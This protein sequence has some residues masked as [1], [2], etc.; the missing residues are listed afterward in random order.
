[1]EVM[2]VGDAPDRNLYF[3]MCNVLKVNLSAG[4][5]VYVSLL[6][7]AFGQVCVDV[8]HQLLVYCYIIIYKL[9]SGCLYWNMMCVVGLIVYLLNSFVGN[10][11]MLILIFLVILLF[12]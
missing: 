2:Y 9:G 1:V 5:N 10:M 11:I 8:N 3:V 7:L 12:F 4:G 6:L